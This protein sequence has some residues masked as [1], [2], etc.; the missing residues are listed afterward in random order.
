MD[1]I[2]NRCKRW[3]ALR[4][5]FLISWWVIGKFSSG[6][7]CRHWRRHLT[8]IR[9]WPNLAK[10]SSHYSSPGFDFLK[11]FSHIW[12]HKKPEESLKDGIFKGETEVGE[13]TTKT[14]VC[15]E[16]N[17]VRVWWWP[18]TTNNNNYNKN[19]TNFT[20]NLLFE[21]AGIS[22]TIYV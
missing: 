11:R 4:N 14:R 20:M 22:T 2:S 7:T 13:K 19:N 15:W 10:N 9:K 12:N 17:R 21:T 3:K 6:T 18:T 8:K 16:R 5:K 1:N